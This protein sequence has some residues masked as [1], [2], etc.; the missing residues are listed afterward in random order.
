MK[1]SSLLFLLVILMQGLSAQIPMINGWM[2]NFRFQKITEGTY[3]RFNLKLSD[4]QGTPYLDDQFAPAKI[5]AS[6]G[7]IYADIPLRYNAYSDDLEF[8]KGNDVYTI[9]P[10]TII[11]RAEF[12]GLVFSCRSYD[13]E[14][15]TQNGFFEVLVDGA[16][17]L[18]VKYTIR[19]LEQDEVKAFAVQKP[20]RFEEVQKQYFISIEGGAA[21]L[22]GNKKSLIEMFGEKKAEM[23]TFI[24]K[25]K[26]AV[27]GDDALTKILVHYNSL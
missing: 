24:S 16:G 14:G 10:K 17:A 15:K 4:I 1:R 12:G 18:L 20:A 7:T 19:F 2:E 11:R 23:E 21:K 6:E 5:I 22:L 9:D 27:K 13:Y 25:N 3:S 26:L 8:K